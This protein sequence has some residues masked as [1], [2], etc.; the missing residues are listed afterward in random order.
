MDGRGAG[1][2]EPGGDTV[3][4]LDVDEVDEERLVL[5]E[6][7][8]RVHDGLTQFI[9]ARRGHLGRARPGR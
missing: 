5:R 7:V 8:A 3:L 6:L 9:I 4:A 1:R 2:L